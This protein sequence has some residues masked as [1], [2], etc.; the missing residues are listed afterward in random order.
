MAKLL[1]GS[2]G[3]LALIT[4]ATVRT[5]PL[6]AARGVALLFF[7]RLEAAASAALQAPP[8]GAVACDLMD[9]RLLTIAREA[10]LRYEQLIPAATEAMLLVEFHGEQPA[11]VRGPLEALVSRVQRQSHL[12]FD[13]RTTTDEEEV[14]FFWQLPRRVVPMLYRLRG[15]ER[16]LPFVEDIA[17]PPAELP[18]FLRRMQDTFKRH[19][20]TASLFAH[21]GHGQLHI[22]PFL[23]LANPAHQELVHRLAEELY[24]E[25]FAVG[26]TIS[27][28]HA[29]GL[30]RTP[31]VRR[32]YGRLYDAFREVKRIF[33]PHNILNPGK[34]VGDD[35]A[36]LQK[37]L[38]VVGIASPEGRTALDATTVGRT[39]RS[40]Q[41]SDEN[42]LEQV[43]RPVPPKPGDESPSPLNLVP[44]LEWSQSD[45]ARLARTC[46][47]CGHC[48]TQSPEMRMCPI[49]RHE[50]TEEASPRAKANLMRAVLS[51]RLPPESLAGDEMKQVVDLCV[52]CHQCRLECPANVDIPK[53]MAEAKGQYVAT[54]G[55]SMGDRLLAR[56]DQL[57][58]LG[59]LAS[60]LAN[61]SVS[62]RQARWLIERMLGVAQGRKL[63][64]F[65][66]R[67]FL[68][69][70]QRRR[71]T[72]PD[73]RPGQKVL[74]FVD[75]Y[76]NWFDVQLA[77]AFIE[78]LQ[79]NGVRVY[80]HPNQHPSG[81]HLVAMGVLDRARRLASRNV[82]LLSE[83]VRQGYTIVTTEPSAALCLK[84]EYPSLL[85]TDDAR[86]VAENVREASTYLWR[87][88]QTGKLE[89]DLQPI[90]A[91]V[92]Y[93]LPCHLRALEVG[94]PGENLLRLVPGLTVRRIEKG[95]SGMAGLYGLRQ[96]NYRASLRTGWGLISALRSTSVQAGTTECTACKMQMEQGTTKPTL[97][98]IKLLALA[99]G[100][101]PELA[102]LLDARGEELVIT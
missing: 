88:H 58:A 27:G 62:N 75:I 69:M 98:P 101:M 49:F 78:V 63:P 91:T 36:L 8:M 82:Q 64:L 6:P 34:V 84:H 53:L 42:N 2:E 30:S 96:E 31:Y 7:D 18:E 10:D 93:H 32:Q 20:V 79:H 97:H 76:A 28:E 25:V 13:A 17:V 52:H 61:W 14:E 81:M 59:S 1:V 85:D 15:S 55:L 65:A 45:I 67:S 57:A 22:R 74:F 51:G 89:L 3:T 16:P 19:A 24:E 99:Y 29:D 41:L 90:N 56:I 92:G 26:G 86:L 38:R 37:H 102:D 33:D 47:G 71:L 60:P 11:D 87:L 4:E 72:R 80:V 5:Q 48:R 21:A 73:R 23:D 66:K 94:S 100:R 50:P 12:A 44:L 40:V 68:R 77:E 54:N 46:N 95:C 35:P 70:A 9:R 39:S 83:A 43:K